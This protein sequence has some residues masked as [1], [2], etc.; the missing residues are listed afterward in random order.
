MHNVAPLN[1]GSGCAECFILES[2]AM[3]MTASCESYVRFVEFDR[4]ISVVK[5]L[6]FFV[7]VLAL[8]SRSLVGLRHIL[9]FVV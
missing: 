2:Y 7:I 6:S 3:E 1:A 8:S 5:K 4:Q 9:F